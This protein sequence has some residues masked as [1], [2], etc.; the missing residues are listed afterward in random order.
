M[1]FSEFPIPADQHPQH[2][3][4]LRALREK[5]KLHLRFVSRATG[6]E[7]VSTTAPMDFGPSSRASDAAPRYHF[8]DYD[9]PRQPHTLSIRAE[10][11]KSMEPLRVRFDP[12]EF[13][14]WAP[15]WHVERDWGVLS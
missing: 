11:I 4:F 1:I 6:E 2:E 9:S 3:D 8:W 15:K 14:T 12:S 7:L 5:R 10:Q 13:V